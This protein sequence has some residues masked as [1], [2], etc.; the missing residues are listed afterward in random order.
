M[1]IC[2]IVFELN[3]VSMAYLV[4]MVWGVA[5]I[6]IRYFQ[7]ILIDDPIIY[8]KKQNLIKDREKMY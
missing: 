3:T 5:I 2:P 4:V 7:I 6:N 8:L 1:N